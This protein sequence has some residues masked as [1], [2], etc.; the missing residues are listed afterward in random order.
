M[1]RQ[2]A[3]K[4]FPRGKVSKQALLVKQGKVKKDGKVTKIKRRIIAVWRRS[5]VNGSSVIPQRIVLPCPI[6]F[7]SDIRDLAE[8]EQQAKSESVKIGYTDGDW[9]TE[10]VTSDFSDEFQHYRVHALLVE[11]HSGKVLECFADAIASKD[12]EL[13]PI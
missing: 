6:D 7:I 13:L 10:L 2:D 11:L 1:R 3:L 4:K 12:E 8:E 5:G 9:G